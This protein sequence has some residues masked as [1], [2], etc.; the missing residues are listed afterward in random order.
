MR[1]AE[2]DVCD[3]VAEAVR[4]RDR[5]VT[6]VDEEQHVAVA[7]VVDADTLDVEALAAAVEL[8]VELCLGEGEDAL[9]LADGEQARP[10]L[11]LVSEEPWHHDGADGLR[12][13]GRHNHV[14]PVQALVGLRHLKLG[15]GE[16]EVCRRER[17]ELAQ[18]QTAP[19]EHL[20]RRSSSPRLVRDRVGE[21][22][23]LLARPEEH[24]AALGRAHT[25]GLR[26]GVA[27]EAVVAHGVVEDGGELVVH[28][29]QVG[30]RVGL[31]LLV[32]VGPQGVEAHEGQLAAGEIDEDDYEAW[33]A[34]QGLDQGIYGLRGRC[35]VPFL[36]R[37]S[38]L[39]HYYCRFSGA[40]MGPKSP[41]AHGVESDKHLSGRLGDGPRSPGITVF[42]DLPL[43]NPTCGFA[44]W[45]AEKAGGLQSDYMA[46]SKMPVRLKTR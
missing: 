25:R 5:R 2:R 22:Q 29:A 42:R 32:A 15:A 19:V 10:L 4:D 34:H 21:A 1:V 26:A 38:S 40:K 27:L 17:Q 41:I 3:L 30:G 37:K 12:R 44:R 14:A 20:G 46:R 43:F 36:C 45:K 18:A 9:V 24:L 28:R 39:S 31:A 16:V 33:K 11:E 7:Q 13:L 8:V 6:H 35:G 23:V